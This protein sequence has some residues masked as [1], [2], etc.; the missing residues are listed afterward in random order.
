MT[1]E[2]FYPNKILPLILTIGVYASGV[3][4]LFLEIL[5]VNHFAGT[6]QPIRPTLHWPDV[7]VGI[8]IYLKTSIDFAIFIGRLMHKYPRWKNRILIEIGTALGNIAGTLAIL[9]L[10]DL[11]REVRVL[12][13]IMIG[14]AALVL[15]RM[16]EEGLDHVRD[17]KG[18]YKVSFGGLEVWL[19][20]NFIVSIN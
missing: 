19:E 5:V 4:M 9:L 10:W 3:G 13:A 14:V 12:M 16:A 1:H 15:L 17:E 8:T 6:R 18:K 20:K 7:L 11:F 2:P